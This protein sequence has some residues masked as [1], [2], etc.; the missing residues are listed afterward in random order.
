MKLLNKLKYFYH[1]S[2]LFFLWRHFVKRNYIGFNKP[3]SIFNFYVLAILLLVHV[4]AFAFGITFLFAFALFY[5]QTLSEANIAVKLAMFAVTTLIIATFKLLKGFDQNRRSD[6]ELSGQIERVHQQ[7]FKIKSAGSQGEDAVNAKIFT[8]RREIDFLHY[9][10]AWTP[11]ENGIHEVVY[12]R[13]KDGSQEIDALIVAGKTVF[14]IEV[15]HWKGLISNQSGVF[16]QNGKVIKSPEEQSKHKVLEL[17]KVL[18]TYDQDDGPPY[19]LKNYDIV[20]IYVFTHKEAK[21]DA[22]LPR[23]YVTLDELADY[24]NAY[25]DK[26]HSVNNQTELTAQHTHFAKSVILHYLD[27]EPNAKH[28][29]LLRLSTYENANEDIKEYAFRKRTLNVQNK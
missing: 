9:G 28:R 15:K 17:D 29:H 21:L 3:I 11:A 5:Y 7:M 26:Y 19:Y 6:F 14:L 1:T 25:R 16:T 13:L 24:F 18:N 23:E 27:R 8:L 2:P 4:Y 10:K 20:P 22:N 12:Q